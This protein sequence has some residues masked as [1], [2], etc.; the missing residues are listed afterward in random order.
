MARDVHSQVHREPIHHDVA[1]EEVESECARNER[2]QMQ[3]RREVQRCDYD[4]AEST[5]EIWSA[6]YVGGDSAFLKDRIPCKSV[7]RK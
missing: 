7:L 6:V 1:E 4:E 2:R 3:H 5:R